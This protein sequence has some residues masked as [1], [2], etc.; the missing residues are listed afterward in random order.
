M[1]K[2]TKED[3]VKNIREVAKS[4][5][6]NIIED[7]LDIVVQGLIAN[8]ELYGD[9]HCPCQIVKDGTQ[10]PCITLDDQMG[11]NGRCHCNLYSV[12]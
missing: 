8:W 5:G 12:D 4:R 9:Y 11:K 10:C 1:K 2:R 6:Y 7:N 3:I